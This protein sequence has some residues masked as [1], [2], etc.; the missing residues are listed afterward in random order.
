M[1]Y[2]AGGF[3]LF[4]ADAAFRMYKDSFHANIPFSKPCHVGKKKKLDVQVHLLS[5]RN[6]PIFPKHTDM[7]VLL[8]ATMSVNPNRIA[9]YN[10]IDICAGKFN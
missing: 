7:I 2:C 4:A 5:K 3:A 10:S 8:K 9:H 1:G 6:Y